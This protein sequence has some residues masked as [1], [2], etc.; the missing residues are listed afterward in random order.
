M[1][2]YISRI[3][4]YGFSDNV[5]RYIQ[6][7]QDTRAVLYHAI[8][9]GYVNDIEILLSIIPRYEENRKYSIT[10]HDLSKIPNFLINEQ[11]FFTKDLYVWVCFTACTAHRIDI[12]D[13]VFSKDSNN[14][15]YIIRIRE[16]IEGKIK[17]M[18]SKSLIKW[19]TDNIYLRID[20][21][22]CG[23]LHDI[24]IEYDE[25][26]LF[27][28][29]FSI[30]SQKES[31]QKNK[32]AQRDI[33]SSLVINE[34]WDLLPLALNHCMLGLKHGI[35]AAGQYRYYDVLMFLSQYCPTLDITFQWFGRNIDGIESKRDEDM[36]IWFLDRIEITPN[37]LAIICSLDNANRCFLPKQLWRF[38]RHMIET[39]ILMHEIS[40][41]DHRKFREFKNICNYLCTNKNIEILKKRIGM[42]KFNF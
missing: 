23:M 24:L 26:E 25:Y 42:S 38:P 17:T 16:I 28:Y 18:K 1:D 6:S 37:V 14:E 3:I 10:D 9:T 12:L 33:F 32:Y 22:F 5:R 15:D 29:W 40:E 35:A 21:N 4:D 31:F 41:L 27:H 8:Y 11:A 34:Q 7:V 20:D 39:V 2:M 36:F 19:Y 30:I 13:F